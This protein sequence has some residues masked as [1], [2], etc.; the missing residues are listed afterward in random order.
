MNVV[1][2]RG[3][4][5]DAEWVRCGRCRGSGEYVECYGD[6]CH[7]QGRCMHDPTNNVCNLCGGTGRITAELDERWY[8]RN[9]FESVTA[10]EADLWNRGTLHAVARERYEGG[11]GR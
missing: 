5:Y 1:R 3:W 10:P 4:W 9:A 7:A 2:E 11:E 6:L 8:S